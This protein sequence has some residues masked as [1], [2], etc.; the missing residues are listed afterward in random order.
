[1]IKL[2]CPWCWGGIRRRN[3]SHR[4]WWKSDIKSSGNIWRRNQRTWKVPCS[5][6]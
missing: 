1:L 6:I 5:K 4:R 3:W 2:Y